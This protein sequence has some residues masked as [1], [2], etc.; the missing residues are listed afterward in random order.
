MARKIRI[1]DAIQSRPPRAAV[2]ATDAKYRR[3]WIVLGAITVWLAA[4]AFVFVKN[5]AG[6]RLFYVPIE[7]LG[8]YGVAFGISCW[9][10]SCRREQLATPP[11]SGP[12]PPPPQSHTFPAPRGVET[13]EERLT[14]L[15]EMRD[16]GLI[17]QAEYKTRRREIIGEVGGNHQPSV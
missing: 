15:S 3:T 9:R 11:P 1:R 17:T 10:R 5:A 6:Q 7:V 2:G 13:I 8:V 12:V 4:M 16:K 14:R